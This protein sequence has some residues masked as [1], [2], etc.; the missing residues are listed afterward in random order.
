MLEDERDFFGIDRCLVFD[1]GEV[2]IGALAIGRGEVFRFEGAV[3]GYIAAADGEAALFVDGERGGVRGSKDKDKGG[4]KQGRVM[5]FL[6]VAGGC[7]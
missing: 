6:I 1:V 2:A 5:G 7:R 4:S 3:V